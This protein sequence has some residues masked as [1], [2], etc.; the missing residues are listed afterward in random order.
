MSTVDLIP[1]FL[2]RE[3]TNYSQLYTTFWD[4]VCG[5]VCSKSEKEMARLYEKGRSSAQVM[6]VEKS[7]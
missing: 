5:T 3:Q 1:G 2:G 4:H 6:E 7:E